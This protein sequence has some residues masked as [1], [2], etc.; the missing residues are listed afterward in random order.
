M[1]MYTGVIYFTCFLNVVYVVLT[2]CLHCFHGN[3]RDNQATILNTYSSKR[4]WLKRINAAMVT[5]ICNHCSIEC[6]Q[7]KWKDRLGISG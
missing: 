5:H 1:Y 4:K 7:S 2:L 3:D 6:L